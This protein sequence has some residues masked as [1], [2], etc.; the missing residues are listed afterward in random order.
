MTSDF[1]TEPI[2]DFE[3]LSDEVVIPKC[4]KRV[5]HNVIIVN[6]AQLELEEM[7]S[8]TLE[9]SPALEANVGITKERSLAEITIIDTD[10]NV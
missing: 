9:R 4:E 2:G 3:F 5:C 1:F 10:S 8:I 7:F 6:D